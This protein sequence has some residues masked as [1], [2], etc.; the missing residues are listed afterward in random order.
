MVTWSRSHV[1]AC[2]RAINTATSRF[3]SRHTTRVSHRIALCTWNRIASQHLR[4]TTHSHT[5]PLIAPSRIASCFALS[6]ASHHNTFAGQ[7]AFL[8]H[9]EVFYRHLTRPSTLFASFPVNLRRVSSSPAFAFSVLR[10]PCS[11]CS[12]I[13]PCVIS[14]RLTPAF[15]AF[16]FCVPC[17]FRIPELC[18][19]SSAH[20]G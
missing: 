7:L 6:I 5:T 19:L 9:Q 4:R 20:S 2:C 16:C 1:L 12:C 18:V 10:S 8:S 11:P 13:I 15:T 3:V 14:L 17:V